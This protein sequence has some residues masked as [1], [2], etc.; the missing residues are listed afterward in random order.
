[1]FVGRSTDAKEDQK[2]CP[3]VGDL[4]RH[5][6]GDKNR[7]SGFHGIHLAPN[8]HF[9]HARQDVVDLLTCPMEM[10][11]CALSWAESCFGQALVFRGRI[12]VGNKL[13]NF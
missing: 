9:S 4:V 8:A 7:C 12:S 6:W 5:S 13:A 3:R 10:E 1:M 2:I 11:S